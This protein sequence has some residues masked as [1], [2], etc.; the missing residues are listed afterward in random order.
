MRKSLGLKIDKN[1]KMEEIYGG[2]ISD[3]LENKDLSRELCRK[4]RR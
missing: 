3:P 1:D 2:S 4:G